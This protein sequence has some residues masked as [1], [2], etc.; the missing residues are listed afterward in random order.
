MAPPEGAGA[1]G[2]ALFLDFDGTLVDI[3]ERPDAVVVEAGLPARLKAVG[4]M[5]DGALAIVTGRALADIDGFMPDLGLDICGL[6]GLERRIGGKLSRP[7]APS[8]LKQAV[9]DLRARLSGTPGIVVEDKGVGAAV[10]WRMAPASEPV[11]RAAMAEF[12]GRLGAGYRIQDGKAVQELVPVH[13]GKDGAVHALM[14]QPPYLGRMPVFVGDDKTDEH[15]FAAVDALGG[16]GVKIG[17]GATAASRRLASPET[18][19]RWLATWFGD[20]AG[21]LALPTA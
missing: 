2:V 20:D 9:D 15:G 17:R 18:F 10:H 16:I 7:E 12:A 3:A 5:L 6:H 13:A 4:A 19:R 14:S 8:G 1:P 21:V 11:A